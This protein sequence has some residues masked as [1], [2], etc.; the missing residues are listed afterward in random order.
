MSRPVAGLLRRQLAAY[1]PLS[2][3]GIVQAALPALASGGD[4]RP[5]LRDVLSLAYSADSVLLTGSGAQALEL[6]LRAA[7]NPV[8]ETPTPIVALPA[9]T[10]FEVAS[11]A[12]G[13]GFRIALYDIE[14]HTLAPDLDSLAAVLSWGAQIV[15]AA[16]LY[17]VPFD[18]QAVEDLAA[19]FGATV[20]E[21]AAQ[22]HGA[23]WGGRTLGSLGAISVLSFG[24]GKGWTGNRGGAVLCRRGSLAGAGFG[25][26][27]EPGPVAEMSVIL[28]ALTQWGFGR[29]SWYAL[30]A[31]LPF[32]GL[33][34]TRYRDPEP[35]AAMGRAAAGL[36]EH[37][38][39]LAELEEFARRANALDLLA[40]MPVTDDVNPVRCQPGGEPGYLRLPVLLSGGLGGFARPREALH[41]GIA[42]GY[43][44]TL[45]ELPAVCARLAQRIGRWPGAETLVHEL[46]TL[47]THSRL[48]TSDRAALGRLFEQY[49]Q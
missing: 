21:D 15:V 18:W 42:P 41:L 16:P 14:P 26:M 17:G 10:C 6:A 25:L 34:E 9:F 2:L 37:T 4:P 31:S 39:P 47:P 38:R 30:P 28:A 27:A 35:P 7:R 44:S 33:G 29:P 23:R 12:V 3:R 32:L 11:A 22:G 24:R 36:I 13:A 20:I 5:A 48:T 45:A 43:P 8:G 46:V 19:G 40:R 49:P 1:S